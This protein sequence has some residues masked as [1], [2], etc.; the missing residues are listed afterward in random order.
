MTNQ[1]MVMGTPGK[2][3]VEDSAQILKTCY[4]I[5][6]EL[7]RTLGGYHVNLDNWTLKTRLPRHVWEDSLR[8]DA[9][10][11]R[12]LEMRYPRRDVDTG[13]H[14]HLLRWLSM[15]IRCADDA[16]LIEGVYFA[17]KRYLLMRYEAY[18]DTADKLEDAPTFAFM[19]SFIPQL[20]QQLSEAEMWYVALPEARKPENR[21]WQAGFTASID[22][23]DVV[24]PGDDRNPYV[25]PLAPKRDTRFTPAAYH[26]PPRN[27]ERFIERQI[28]QG[29]NHTNEIWA[30][31]APFLV[32]WQWTDMP[33]EF[34]LDMA[35]WGYD[36]SR[37]CLMGEERLLAWGFE[38][39]VHY[40]VVGDHYMSVSESGELAVMALLHRFETSGPAWKS[41]LKK[42]FEVMGDLSS[43]QDFDYDW[44]DESIHLAYGHKWVL[45]KL[46]GNIDAYEDL[47]DEVYERWDEWI[48]AKHKTWDYEPFMSR[49]QSRIVELE[50][51]N[52]E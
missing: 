29:I 12:V 25:P 44:A 26:M 21:S 13:H 51:A 10:R 18:L 28:W 14:P 27:P 11:T 1:T 5:E 50:G 52:I 4:L 16:E 32:M 37:H 15:L 42:D 40:P 19:Q 33:W 47:L 48:A 31:E 46:G 24:I 30:T 2:R 36:E 20:R 35:R 7:M 22:K 39:G 34:Y 17:A 45:H 41:G 6:R 9:L 3:N 38:P 43:S 49:I 8:A 23:E